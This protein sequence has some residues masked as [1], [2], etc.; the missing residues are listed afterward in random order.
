MRDHFREYEV[1]K[2][3]EDAAAKAVDLTFL[4]LGIDVNDSNSLNAMRDHLHFLQRMSR[5]ADLVNK[6]I[7]KTCIGALVAGFIAMVVLGF[8]DTV[9]SWF[10]R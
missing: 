6:T 9:L 8:K 7:V 10:H 1:R 2:I 4:H 3:A 5:A